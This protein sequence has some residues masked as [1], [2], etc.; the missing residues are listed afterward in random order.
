MSEPVESKP[1]EEILTAR[2][3]SRFWAVISLGY[4]VMAF[5]LNLMVWTKLGL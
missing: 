5:V 1:E 3:A 2:E 4:A